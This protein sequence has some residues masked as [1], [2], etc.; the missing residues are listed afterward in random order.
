MRRRFSSLLALAVIAAIVVP[1][2]PASAAT[3]S[4][5]RGIAP[6]AWNGGSALALSS[7]GSKLTS[8]YTTDFIGG[9]FATDSGPFMGVFAVSSTD[10]GVTWSAPVRVSQPSSQADR[11][12]I[13]SDGGTLYAAW[14]TQ[15]SYVSYDPGAPRVLYVR[16][17]AG[18]GW[19]KTTALT[20][21][22]GRV[23]YPSI[24]AAAGRVYVA[25]TDAKTGRVTVARSA[26]QGATWKRTVVGK[27]T[28]QSNAGEGLYGAPAIGASGNVV[29]L[30]WIASG[31]GTLKARI[32]TN[33][34]KSW[35]T[36][37]T[38]EPGL[39]AA[40]GG[41]PA[42]TGVAKG[43]AFAW[44]TPGG[45]WAAVSHGGALGSARQVSG[46]AAPYQGGYGVAITPGASDAIGVA[47]S[48]CRTAG[49]NT[50]STTT[51][52]DVLWSES[53]DGGASWSAAQ[54]VQG[55]QKAGQ[56]LNDGASA[57]W[58]TD[59]ARVVS[60][61]GYASGF[62]TYGLFLKGGT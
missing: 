43:V 55:S 45:V 40:N 46:F 12:V 9:S 38:L 2:V 6:R 59:G 34:G 39:A 23:D 52:I 29:G 47:W 53:S 24:A 41:A 51:K 58:G 5:Q 62:T 42:A 25:W 36:T 13:A 54:L 17:N 28:A 16:S 19:G 1:A 18:G 26:T 31:S 60:Y 32:S 56:A 3:W 61:T 11:G 10:R 33:G 44:T 48:A 49:C 8:L 14:V 37:G 50:L 21:K 22:K 35:G 4:G 30:A 27:T 20:S 15:Q 57:V 7:A